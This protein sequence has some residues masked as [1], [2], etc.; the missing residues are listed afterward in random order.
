MEML[1]LRL[2]RSVNMHISQSFVK[3][4]VKILSRKDDE[5]HEERKEDHGKEDDHEKD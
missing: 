2:T 5:D 4:Y 1:V 3:C